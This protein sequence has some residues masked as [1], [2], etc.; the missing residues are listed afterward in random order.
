MVKKFV[1]FAK[2][3]SAHQIKL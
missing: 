1:K 2:F 3:I